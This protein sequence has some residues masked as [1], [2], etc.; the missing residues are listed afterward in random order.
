MR[1][2]HATLHDNTITWSDS[3]LGY[4]MRYADVPRELYDL[5]NNKRKEKKCDSL[6][7]IEL[8]NSYHTEGGKSFSLVMVYASKDWHKSVTYEVP[9][10]RVGLEFGQYYKRLC[11]YLGRP[12]EYRSA[13]RIIRN[14]YECV[15]TPAEQRKL[16]TLVFNSTNPAVAEVSRA[17][18]DALNRN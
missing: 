5:V 9:K 16:V 15:V 18:L 13:P 11:N 2:L 17:L 3:P 8:I 1:V 10:S 6:L 14:L 12:Y 4:G 7:T